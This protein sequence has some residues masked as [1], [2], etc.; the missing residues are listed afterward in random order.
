MLRESAVE[1]VAVATPHPVGLVEAALASG[2]HVFL[3][4]PHGVTVDAA[5]RIAASV[6][7]SG[8]DFAAAPFD[9]SWDAEGLGRIFDSLRFPKSG[10]MRLNVT[11][12]TWDLPTSDGRIAW[13][14]RDV[15][16]QAVRATPRARL[17]RRVQAVVAP[18]R[19]WSVGLVIDD[20]TRVEIHTSVDRGLAPGAFVIEFETPQQ[21]GIS[22]AVIESGPIALQ[23][24]P[25]AC[26]GI[27]L[28]RFLQRN[29]GRYSVTEPERMEALRGL[30]WSA[31]LTEALERN[32]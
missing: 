6:E 5:K 12:S 7:R 18:G 2:K 23:S 15:L 27:G 32:G 3:A 8:L 11:A 16:S 21:Y 22:R 14:G 25:D 24:G 28:Q 10:R 4:S 9:L 17:P 30:E 1:A 19:M 26:D 20:S 31:M 29:T 13:V